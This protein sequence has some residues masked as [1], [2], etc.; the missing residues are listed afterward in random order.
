MTPGL[1]DSRESDTTT[2]AV[3][4][5]HPRLHQLLTE[6][7]STIS[8]FELMFIYLARR[9]LRVRSHHKPVVQTLN[10]DEK[11]LLLHFE[12]LDY[13]GE[14]VQNL[15]GIRY[16]DESE[17]GYDPFT[18]RL[19]YGGREL[20]DFVVH[21]VK[22]SLRF[23]KYYIKSQSIWDGPVLN[24]DE[25]DGPCQG[26][27]LFCSKPYRKGK[28]P[29]I[30]SRQNLLA[31]MHDH[32]PKSLA[33][34]QEIAAITSLFGQEPQSVEYI[35]KLAEQAAQ[36]GFRGLLNF[37]TC[38][39]RSRAYMT[40]IAATCQTLGVGFAYTFSAEKYFDRRSLMGPAKGDLNLD[41]IYELLQQAIDCYGRLNVGYN[42]I[43]GV[44]PLEDFRKGFSHLA[45]T[46]AVPHLNIF[47]PITPKRD[48]AKRLKTRRRSNAVDPIVKTR[49]RRFL[50]NS[51]SI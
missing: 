37:M 23:G 43:L 3:V 2:V 30:D 32:H 24:L 9:G 51:T 33:C 44:E 14:P 38:Q 8:P 50:S 7:D 12:G 34:F 45:A 26:G 20:S 36:L 13:R 49:K 5:A 27:C 41:G 11:T 19:S 42:Y 21:H 10:D 46:G 22:R 29:V 18:Q 47:V 39:V 4:T 16:N 48:S 28:P 6:C 15:D 17:F 31:V 25:N 1:S 35:L 40:A